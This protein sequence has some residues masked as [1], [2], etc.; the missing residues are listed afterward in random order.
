MSLYHLYKSHTFYGIYSINSSLILCHILDPYPIL[1]VPIHQSIRRVVRYEV[2][3][4]VVGII[5]EIDRLRIVNFRGQSG[6]LLDHILVG[7][8]SSEGGDRELRS[9]ANQDPPPTH[10]QMTKQP[11]REPDKTN[12]EGKKWGWGGTY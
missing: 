12:K 8:E 7:R 6:G 9:P 10:P 4:T 1:V 3:V 5:V 11:T 2:V